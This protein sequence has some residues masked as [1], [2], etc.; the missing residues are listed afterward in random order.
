MLNYSVAELRNIK[1]RVQN[2]NYFPIHTKKNEKKTI[3]TPKYFIFYTKSIQFLT[4]YKTLCSFLLKGY[5]IRMPLALFTKD[6]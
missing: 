5:M 2:Y 4:F 6:K 3:F 1:Y